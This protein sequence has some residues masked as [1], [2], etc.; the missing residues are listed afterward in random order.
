MMPSFIFKLLLM[1]IPIDNL[2]I[3]MRQTSNYNTIINNITGA[4][5][6]NTSFNIINKHTLEYTSYAA[7]Y[8]V[9]NKYKFVMNDIHTMPTWM[10]VMNIGKSKKNELWHREI[11]NNMIP[12]NIFVKNNILLH[13][14]TFG[15]FKIDILFRV[16]YNVFD[17]KNGVIMASTIDSTFNGDIKEFDTMIWVFP[18][19]T[20]KDLVVVI[21][22]GHINS[23]YP[24]SLFS[25]YIKWHIDT[26]LENLGNRLIEVAN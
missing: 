21:T 5:Y 20:I 19:P 1:I 12:C 14:K 17:V 25:G 4:T 15:I 6:P 11:H 7:Y 16:V 26:I 23:Q 24:I 9:G 2:V 18:H 3:M 13:V 8:D 22:Q 10:L